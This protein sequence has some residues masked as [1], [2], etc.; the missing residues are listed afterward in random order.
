V[1]AA[2]ARL[3]CNAAERR[4]RELDKVWAEVDQLTARLAV[5]QARARK[6]EREVSR[7]RGYVFPQ[8]REVLSRP[9]RGR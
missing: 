3:P 8:S 6:L 4:Q 5:A 9:G 7:D 2:I 1:S